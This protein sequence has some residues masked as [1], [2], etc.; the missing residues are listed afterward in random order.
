MSK[1]MTALGALGIALTFSSALGAQTP[2]APR[3]AS[4]DWH[5]VDSVLGRKGTAQPGDVMRYAFPRIDLNVT[6]DGV[7]LEPAFALGS[8]VAFKRVGG[9]HTVAAGDL[10][11]VEDELGA[12]LSE[13]QAGGVEQT[14]VHNH[15][16]RE[17]PRI[18][19]VHIHA[20]GDEVSI[21]RTIHDALA[22]TTAVLPTAFGL[23]TPFMLTA[24]T[25]VDTA[26]VANALGYRGRMNAR[27][28]Q[29]SVP[30]AQK[31]LDAGT[32]IP[33]SMGVATAINFQSTGNGNAAVTGDFVMTADEVNKV[34]RALHANK[35]EVTAL[36]SHML[37][38][39]PRLFFMH[40]WANANAVTL[41][42][43]LR[44]ALSQMDVSRAARGSR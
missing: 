32:E 31:I 1:S 30:R 28:Y 18:M 4:T 39:S 37:T 22:L 24:T 6:V 14:A 40:F 35:I 17:S 2:V 26:A 41:A 21:A 33:P 20:R 15:L 13:L 16:L 19:Y 29:V 11:L 23:P 9:G 7:K 38:E 8:W 44:A 42:R 34:I 12:V 36:H 27:V 10:V 5:A 3:P 25:I 43:G